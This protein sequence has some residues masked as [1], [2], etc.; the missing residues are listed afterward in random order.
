[1]TIRLGTKQKSGKAALFRSSED[2]SAYIYI[3]ALV[4]KVDKNTF[5]KGLDART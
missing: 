4:A 3:N 5:F 1:M 2:K